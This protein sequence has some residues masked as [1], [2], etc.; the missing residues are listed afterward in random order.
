MILGPKFIGTLPVTHVLSMSLSVLVNYAVHSTNTTDY[1][2]IK[3]WQV[4]KK[5][6]KSREQ[7]KF[8]YKLH[9]KNISCTLYSWHNIK[10]IL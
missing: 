4:R 10:I 1:V 6:Y 8:E 9:E 3:M 2:I 7:I 5:L